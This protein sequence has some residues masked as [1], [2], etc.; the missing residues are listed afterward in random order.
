MAP[1]KQ[2]H[3][4]SNWNGETVLNNVLASAYAGQSG[5]PEVGSSGMLSPPSSPPLAALTSAN[6]LALVS[7]N[8]SN[9]KRETD[10][11]RKSRKE[12]A[13]FL[14]REECERLFC[15]TM[16][17]VFLGDAGKTT[18]NGSIAI[19]ANAHSP[20]DESVNV[21]NDYF[22]KRPSQ[23]LDAW[24]EIWDYAGGCSFR[25]FVGGDGDKKS[26]FAFF[27]SA[28]VGRDLKQGLMALI[29]LADT[30][31][32]VNQVVICLD[33]NV[34][35]ADRKVFLKSLRW[36]GFELISLD[37]WANDLDVTSEKWLYLGMEV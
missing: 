29:E 22:V 20:P 21:Y 26:L 5:I 9:P 35:D 34:P 2:N 37:M 8:N 12:G 10:G 3:S 7:K 28:V 30:V 13:A 6:E 33:R 31:F 32:A 1:S 19:G 27:D 4:S 23:A 25:A 14:I 16:K 17:V 15:E 24:V 18:N 36:V 11:R